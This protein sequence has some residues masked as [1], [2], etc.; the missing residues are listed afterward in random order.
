MRTRSIIVGALATLC[1]VGAGP[2]FGGGLEFPD[3]GTAATARGGAFTAKADDPTALIHNPGAL[4]LLRGT[5][6]L[7]NHTLI[8]SFAT[9]QRS[10]SS[11]ADPTVN[12][13]PYPNTGDPLAPVINESAL[14]PFNGMFIATTD[15]GLED[16]T[17][18]IGIY[19]PN[20]SGGSEYPSSG[21]QRYMMTKLDAIAFYPSLSVSYGDGEHW[22]IGVTLQMPITPHL[23]MQLVVDGSA[24]GPVSAYYDGDDVLATVSLS[25]GPTFS[26]LAG[27]WFRPIPELEIGLSGRVIPVNLDLEGD[28]FLDNVPGQTQFPANQLEVQGAAARLSIT[29]PPTAKFGIRYRHLDGAGQE[30]FDIEADVV[31]E[32]WSV[33]DKFAVELDGVAGLYPTVLDMP[34]VTIDKRWQDT[35]SVRLGGTI[36]LRGGDL[37]VSWGSFWERAAVPENYENIDFLSFDRLG[38]SMGIA[39]KIGPV[40]LSMAY[41]HIFQEDREVDERNSKV[42]QQRPINPCPTDCQGGWDGVPANNGTFKS[43]FD[44][45]S[46]G[47]EVAL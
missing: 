8:W 6:L 21:G 4:H 44:V 9:F 47:V 39:G 32:A 33:L 34:D 5:H 45:I 36:N 19:G 37:M 31:Y 27:A 14:F 38:L 41:M 10:A 22:G 42:Y 40:K 46:M 26:A 35:F 7:L 20:G 16:W 24:R 3:S 28:W 2:A 29:L 11:F 15:F 17:F 43:G 30:L 12:P 23:E 13:S 18:G 1:V 25:A